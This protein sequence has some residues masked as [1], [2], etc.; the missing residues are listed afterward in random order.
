MKQLGTF[1]LHGNLHVT[2]WPIAD[3]INAEIIRSSYVIKSATPMHQVRRINAPCGVCGAEINASLTLK[4]KICAAA[5]M[6][7]A[8]MDS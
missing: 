7:S 3:R 1:R 2:G 8:C 4:I 6:T 5:P